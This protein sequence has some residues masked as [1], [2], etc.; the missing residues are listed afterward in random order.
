MALLDILEAGELLLSWR[1]YA[2]VAITAA[3]CRLVLQI[4]SNDTIG[5][6]FCAPIGI[7]GLVASVRWQ[8]R[9]GDGL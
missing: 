2:G 8:I 9:S 3:I 7:I 1:L 5:W 4:V 6:F